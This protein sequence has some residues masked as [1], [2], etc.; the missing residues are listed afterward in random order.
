MTPPLF[1]AE[2]LPAGDVL[3]LAGEEGRH[4]ARVKRLRVGEPVLV[5]DGR[6]SLLD[7][8]VSAVGPDGLRLSVSSRRFVAPAAPRLVVVQALPKGD[9]AELAVEVLTELGADEIVPWAAAR[10]IVHW[11]GPRGER[12]WEKW[13][14]TA[15]EATKQSRRAWLPT[16]APLAS[17]AEVA[18]RLAGGVGLV[19]HEDAAEPLATTALPPDR[20][21]VVVVGPEGGIA[22]DELSDFAAVGARPVRLGEPVLRTSTAGAAALAVLSTRLGRWG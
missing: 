21:V 17:T 10:A 14:R 16:V 3:M 4:A 13:R 22:P 8:V 5:S 18:A 11:I 9:R 12:A 19:L 15:R 2:E 7:C 6:G 20:D 1:L